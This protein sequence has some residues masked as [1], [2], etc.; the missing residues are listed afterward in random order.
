MTEPVTASVRIAAPP[1]VVF[2][3]FTDPAL[4]VKWIAD[5]AYLDARPGG[6]L[7]IDVRGNPARGEYV[8]VEPPQLMEV[9]AGRSIG[10]G[11]VVKVERRVA[12]LRRMD[13]FV[14]GGALHEL[15]ERELRTTTRLLREAATSLSIDLEN[16]RY[17]DSQTF[18]RLASDG[19]VGTAGTD[20]QKLLDKIN[21]SGLL[22]LDEDVTIAMDIPG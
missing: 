19:W 18:I 1:E 2:P 15:V 11:L 22:R 8:V 13:D 5:A 9:A 16:D 12:Q 3:Y 10:D 7:A 6:T 21:A 4:A 17:L 20:T 14:A